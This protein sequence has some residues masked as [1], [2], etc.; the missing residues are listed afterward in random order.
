MLVVCWSVFGAW[1]SSS[2]SFGMDF[3]YQPSSWKL[4]LCESVPNLFPFS[5]LS[6]SL[7]SRSLGI[8]SSVARSNGTIPSTNLGFA[9]LI[10][11]IP[12]VVWVK[13]LPL[14]VHLLAFLITSSLSRFS[15][16]LSPRGSWNGIWGL[17][18]SCPL[19][20]RG[21]GSIRASVLNFFYFS[22]PAV[23]SIIT[24]VLS[25]LVGFTQ[26]SATHRFEE[27]QAEMSKQD[28]NSMP[29]TDQINQAAK[30][31]QD[32]AYA[33]HRMAQGYTFFFVFALLITFG[34]AA[35][36]F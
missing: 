10:L 24:L 32:G 34:L 13:C 25:L 30:V 29:T 5:F 27:F 22:I 12:L 23:F 6:A 18:L 2:R 17:F 14:S 19:G 7:A 1:V 4:R 21:G 9:P 28:P 33:W 35:V 26:R 31:F 15:L 11:G 16:I 36:G 8:L 3:L 20:I